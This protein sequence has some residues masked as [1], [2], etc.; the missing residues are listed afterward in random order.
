MN[1]AL[2]K[3]KRA[4]IWEAQERKCKYCHKLLELSE[5]TMDHI[6]PVSKG[7]TGRFENLA[8][9]CDKCNSVKGDKLIDEVSE[10]F[11]R[12]IATIDKHI[13]AIVEKRRIDNDA[14][15]ARVLKESQRS[16]DAEV[17]L[18]EKRRKIEAEA[19]LYKG[20]MNEIRT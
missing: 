2:W 9:A 10:S 15:V 3:K 20:I 7:G 19:A 1:R 5:A 11:K 12:S 18:I 16:V 13:E 14:M 17:R 8:V 6:V 4:N